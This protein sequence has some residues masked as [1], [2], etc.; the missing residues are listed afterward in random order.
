LGLAALALV[1]VTSCGSNGGDGRAGPLGTGEASAA[2]YTVRVLATYDHDDSAFTQGL[3]WAGDDQ[4][5]ESAGQYGSSSLRRVEIASGDVLERHD[6]DDDYFAEGL[7]QVDDRLI[8]LT[9]KENVAFV[10]DADTFE[11]VGT[12][13]YEGEGWGLC[14]DG[15]RLV[16]SDGTATLTFRDESTFESTDEVVVRRAG[17]PVA[18]LNEL[19]CVGDRVYANVYGSDR[20]VE[21]DPVSGD[22]TAE[23]DASSI[24]PA[25]SRSRSDVL[26]G[27]AYDPA[28][29]TFYLTGK[30]WPTLYAVSFEKA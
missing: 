18:A 9:W 13:D 19:E 2:D 5:F 1:G 21:I 20:I 22:V 4:L 6:L 3:V 15:D 26:N 16:M 23:I 28:D 14:H 30:N 12:F 27:I 25:G 10:Y 8:Q 24:H 7:A 17:Q 11:Q 29:G